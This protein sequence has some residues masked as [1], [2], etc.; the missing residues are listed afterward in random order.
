MGTLSFVLAPFVP[1][2]LSTAAAAIALGT[3]VWS[4]AIDIGRLWQI[5]AP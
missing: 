5:R 1:V 3:L 2:A 4:F